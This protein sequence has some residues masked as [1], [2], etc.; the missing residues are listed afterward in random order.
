LIDAGEAVTEPILVEIWACAELKA[1]DRN[2]ARHTRKHVCIGPLLRG[3]E[4][5]M[6]IGELVFNNISGKRRPAGR[7]S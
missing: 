5:S 4:K 2:A 7:H 3:T 1:K 6:I